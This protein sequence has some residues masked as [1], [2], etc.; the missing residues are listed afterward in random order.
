MSCRSLRMVLYS[1]NREISVS[2]ALHSI[3]VYID[4]GY[5]HIPLK[6]AVK[7]IAVILGCNIAPACDEILNRIVTA[8]VAELKFVCTA[9]EGKPQKLVPKTY[10]K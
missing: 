9:S 4:L 8:M 1:Q 10:A 6:C 5:F 3:I 7:S 2:E